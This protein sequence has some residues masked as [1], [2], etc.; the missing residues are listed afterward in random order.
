MI[1]PNNNP[2]LELKK[3]HIDRRETFS[4]YNERQLQQ[5]SFLLVSSNYYLQ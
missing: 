1:I 2:D 4:N 3:N 5:V